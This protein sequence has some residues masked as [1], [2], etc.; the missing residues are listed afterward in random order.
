[1][2]TMI[3]DT[4]FLFI[5]SYFLPVAGYMALRHLQFAW[6]ERIWLVHF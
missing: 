6:W 3:K 5:K 4:F 2:A 1:M